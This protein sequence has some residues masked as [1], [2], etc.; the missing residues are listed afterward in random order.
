VK[1]SLLSHLKKLFPEKTEKE[2]YAYILY[3]NIYVN[4]EKVREPVR[5]ID[6]RAEVEIRLK[7][8]VSRGGYKL[9]GALEE[10]GIDCRNKIFI[11]AGSSTGGF[12]DCLLQRGA[13]LVYSVDVGFNQLDFSLRNNE[14][15]RVH[16]KCNIMDMEEPDPQ[17]HMGVAD[18]SFRSIGGAASKIVDLTSEKKLIALI[19]PQFEIEASDDF[20]GVIKDPAQ[21]RSVLLDVCKSL[22]KEGLTVSRLLPSQIKGKRGGNQEFLAFIEK[23]E[24]EEYKNFKSAI[25]EMVDTSLTLIKNHPG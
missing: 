6:S 2:L 17:P 21:W 10:W 20:K 25:I 4:D 22:F 5:Q 7:K 14:R 13:A 9:D 24:F 3:G 11:D 15:V 12:T 19:K 8:Y 23:K 16:E 1:L 18:L